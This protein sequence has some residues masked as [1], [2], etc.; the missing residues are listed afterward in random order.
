MRWRSL[1]NVMEP[2]ILSL[3]SLST[4]SD[5]ELRAGVAQLQERREA[6]AAEAR[7]R[8]AS[9]AKLPKTARGPKTPSPE[10][11]AMLALLKGDT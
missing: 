1:L 10:D 5:E 4:K 7:A 6:L 11:I 9:G 3:G 2:L 8:R